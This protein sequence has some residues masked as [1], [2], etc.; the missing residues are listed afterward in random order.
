MGNNRKR[1]TD[2]SVPRLGL[3]SGDFYS[4]SVM[5][6]I[7]FRCDPSRRMLPFSFSFA[8]NRL[9]REF[10]TICFIRQAWILPD[11]VN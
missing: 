4:S 1:G 5:I 6:H 10:L 9:I 3:M 7:P 8:T 2:E 11:N